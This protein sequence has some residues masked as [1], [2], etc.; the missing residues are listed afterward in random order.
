MKSLG[1]SFTDKRKRYNS[2]IFP[3]NTMTKIN[4]G[5]E[6]T[7]KTIMRLAIPSMI[8]QLVNVLYSIVDRIYVSNMGQDGSL[9]L[10][11]IGVCAPIT[12]LISSFAFLVG[13]GGAPLFSMALGAKDE[14]RAKKILSN[15]F[16]MLIVLSALLM[17]L[18]Y[19][20]LEPMLYAFGA[21]DASYPFAKA[22]MEI[23]LAGT[24]FSIISYGLNQFLTA[25][26]ESIASML[27]ILVAC[28]CNVALDP[29]FIYVFDMGVQ[30]ASLATIL[31]QGISFIWVLFYLF[32][33]ARVRLSFGNYSRKIM[34]QII[35]LGLSP[36]IIMATDSVVLIALNAS[37]QMYGNQFDGQGDFY[38]EV[39]TI[40]QA[41]ESLITGPLLGISSGTQPILSYN[42]GAK[43]IK[44]IVKAEKQIVIFGLIFTTI[45]FVLSFFVGEGF[46]KIFVGLSQNASNL[47]T[48]AIIET[49]AR[50]IRVYM[51][52]IILLS[53]QYTLVD[54]LTG[55]GQANYSIWLSL[56]RKVIILLP[57]IFI[58]PLLLQHESGAFY[59]ELLADCT[60]GIVSTIVYALLTPRILKK[61]A[62]LPK[63]TSLKELCLYT[64]EE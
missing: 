11:G 61:R 41:F 4:L 12:T 35:R 25:Q 44:R 40:V 34:F 48:Q 38:I 57:A 24:F 46:A 26:G 9:A 63:N 32:R 58:F 22:Y 33:K 1:F 21:S 31:C 14:E 16:L 36:F 50:F 37:L 51:Y 5:Q 62:G 64:G 10:I 8:A 19:L 54:G 23:Y 20:L 49:S 56:N 42:Y 27:T 29:V 2:V 6:N 59:A 28:L 60:G 17:G 53:L 55:M 18:G 39:A 45:C 30:G 7:L 47:D 52:G 13:L 3:N 15:A 43:N